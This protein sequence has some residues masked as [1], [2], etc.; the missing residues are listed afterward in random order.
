MKFQNAIALTGSIATG[1]SSVCSLL[2][3]LG[4]SIIDAD[5]IAHEILDEKKDEII[6]AFGSQIQTQGKIDRKLLGKII[7]N[8]CDLRK[9]LESIVHPKI[10]SKIQDLCVALEKTQTP[11]IVDI[12]LFFETKG[13]DF[14]FVVVVYAPYLAQQERLVSREGLELEEAKKRIESQIDIEKKKKLA[15]FVIDNS[16]NLKHLQKEVEK[17]LEFLRGKYANLKI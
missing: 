14:D 16:G 5:K 9:K 11:Y 8:N 2:R 1:K 10:R 13:Y 15:N 4:F 3:L 12:P 17:F 7:F 6:E